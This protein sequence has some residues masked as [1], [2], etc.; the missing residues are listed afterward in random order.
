MCYLLIH[1]VQHSFYLSRLI[2]VTFLR[3]NARFLLVYFVKSQSLCIFR[4]NQSYRKA[5]TKNSCSDEHSIHVSAQHEPSNGVINSTL[6]VGISSIPD[7]SLSAL[8]WYYSIKI[9]VEWEEWCG[10][11]YVWFYDTNDRTHLKSKFHTEVLGVFRA[12]LSHGKLNSIP[13]PGN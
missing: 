1:L 8:V 13:S 12:Y 3:K 10:H 11:V 7:C 4:L 2:Y 6:R 9:T 5:H